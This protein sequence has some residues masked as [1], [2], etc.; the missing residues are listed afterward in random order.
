MKTKEELRRELAA[1]E[2]YKNTITKTQKRNQ[3][4]EYYRIE[5]KVNQLK[6]ILE[7]EE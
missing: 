2:G 1:L 7:E 3:T 6:W 4:I 5:A